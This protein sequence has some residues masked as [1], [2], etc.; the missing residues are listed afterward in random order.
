MI[1]VVV[2]SIVIGLFNNVLVLTHSLG[3]LYLAVA[4]QTHTLAWGVWGLDINGQ[5][6]G[7]AHEK[8][9]MTAESHTLGHGLCG[10]FRMTFHFV[11]LCFNQFF[12]PMVFQEWMRGESELNN[13]WL[14]AC[15]VV[16]HSV[17]LY[18]LW[19]IP[20]YVYWIIF[21]CF[22]MSLDPKKALQSPQSFLVFHGKRSLYWAL[23]RGSDYFLFCIRF[24]AMH[25]ILDI[26][27][28]F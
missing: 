5:E 11:N 18:G 17:K 21:L 20:L 26:Y 27:L 13:Q 6:E 4:V 16:W 7:Q 28:Q 22:C 1:W 2:L 8:R 15:H 24:Q 9:S 23:Y 3:C 12:R 19:I 25:I 10:P 14:P